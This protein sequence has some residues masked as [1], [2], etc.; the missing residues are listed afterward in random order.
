VCMFAA[1][2]IR[3]SMRLA[4]ADW[5]VRG[6]FVHNVP[7]WPMR[8]GRLPPVAAKPACFAIT[9]TSVQKKFLLS[10]LFAGEK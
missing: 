8:G 3:M 7:I 9:G 4:K 5:H 10:I 6:T 2:H 1:P